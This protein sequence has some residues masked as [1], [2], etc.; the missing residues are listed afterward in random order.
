MLPRAQ[1]AVSQ[2]HLM[3]L[4]LDS[5]GHSSQFAQFFGYPVEVSD[6][7]RMESAIL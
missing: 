2:R 1:I 7:A 4:V 5:N 3:P 6:A